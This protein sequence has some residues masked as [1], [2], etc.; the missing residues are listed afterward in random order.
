M[1][2]VERH[3][4][5]VRCPDPADEAALHD[6]AMQAVGTRLPLNR[7][8]WA[9]VIVTGLAEDRGALVI[10]FHH[11][12]ADGIGGLAV[13]ARLIDGAPPARDDR[14]PRQPP[15]RRV[16][17]TDAL[18]GRTR[19]LVHLHRGLRQ[20][21]DAVSELRSTQPQHRGPRSTVRPARGVRSAWSVPTL[22]PCTPLP[23][24]TA[25][26]STTS[27]SPPWAERWANCWPTRRA[28]RGRRRLG[29]DLRAAADQ[30]RA[31]GQ[32]GRCAP[33]RRA[34]TRHTR[35]AARRPRAPDRG[36]HTSPHEQRPRSCSTPDSASSQQP[37]FCL[38]SSTTST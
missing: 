22:P 16:L 23:T 31:A 37:A 21:R 7:P 30:R 4:R 36:A 15:T 11:V 24:D 26:R 34:H 38:G 25:G 28:R 17:L 32:R 6:V 27:C 33:R 2:T 18:A 12:L 35:R 5:E 1:F 19:A 10:V 3:V 13:L 14:F 20:V 9:A 29:A 8:P